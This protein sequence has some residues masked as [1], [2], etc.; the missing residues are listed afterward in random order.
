M[1]KTHLIEK[2]LRDHRSR[3]DKFTGVTRL[4]VAYVQMP[5]SPNERDFYRQRNFL[6]QPLF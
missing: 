6:S 5:R 3:F 4:P 2:F 1:G